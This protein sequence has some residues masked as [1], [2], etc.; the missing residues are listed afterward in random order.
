VLF[1]PLGF[2][3]AAQLSKRGVAG[4]VGVLG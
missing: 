2:Q 3:L 4:C 1:E